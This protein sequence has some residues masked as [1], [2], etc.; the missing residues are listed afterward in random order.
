[1][2]IRNYLLLKNYIIEVLS[3]NELEMWMRGNY[4]RMPIAPLKFCPSLIK[5]PCHWV[6]HSIHWFYCSLIPKYGTTTNP[7]QTNVWQDKPRT[8][9]RRTRQTTDKCRTR[10]TPDMLLVGD[11]TLIYFHFQVKRIV[12]SDKLLVYD[13]KEGWEPLCTFLGLPVPNNPF[14]R[15]NDTQVHKWGEPAIRSI[16]WFFSAFNLQYV[17]LL[18]NIPKNQFTSGILV[19]TANSWADVPQYVFRKSFVTQFVPSLLIQSL[20]KSVFFL[21]CD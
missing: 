12:P 7:W 17:F 2:S 13:V 8:E 1:M 4:S 10:Q 19:W 5:N 15:V 14:P 3:E 21:H 9:K 16:W 18:N 11:M 6:F 20:H